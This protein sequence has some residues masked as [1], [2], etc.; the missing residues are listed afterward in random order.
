MARKR[1]GQ[2]FLHE[3]GV[4]DRIVSMLA[5]AADDA[6]VEIGPG[7]GALTEPLLERVDRLSVIEIDRDLIAELESRAARD[8]RLEV[9]AGDALRIDY[10]ALAERRGPLRLVGNL[11]YNISSP[12][13]FAL[14]GSA[15]PI[16]DMHFM[17]QKEV[18]DRMTAEPG[19][20]DYGRLTVSVAARAHAQALFDV[21]PGAFNPPPKVMSSVVRVTPRAPDFEIHDG[22]LF[23]Q[24]VTAAFSQRRKTLRNAL[25]R[26]LDA[27]AIEA[28]NIDPMLRPERLAAADFARLANRA[29]KE[30][31]A[32]STD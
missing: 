18:V 31:R 19:S 20:R 3:R 22:Q 11:P 1:F 21:A 25:G 5:P 24:L 17:L 4:I 13:L 2:H 16:I 10:A 23:D 9:I 27:Q 30:K 26:F 7:Q 29:S 12:L 15:A 6:L 8:S 28:C 32:G 14:L